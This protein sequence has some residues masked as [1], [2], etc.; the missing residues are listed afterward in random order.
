M[1]DPL[2]ALACGSV[3]Q[4]KS[5]SVR[6]WFGLDASDVPVE[7]DWGEAPGPVPSRDVPH[8]APAE[9]TI[10]LENEA[11]TPPAVFDDPVTQVRFEH[12]AV[13]VNVS[14]REWLAAH[15]G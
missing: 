5:P 4:P 7:L 15:Q 11:T 2:R 9:P 3:V 12:E 10:E 14:L 8:P 1:M 13:V 6:A